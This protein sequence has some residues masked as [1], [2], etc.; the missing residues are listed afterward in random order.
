MSLEAIAPGD[1]D[2]VIGL[3][4]LIGTRLPIPPDAAIDRDD[5]VQECVLGALR[6]APRWRP[7][8]GTTFQAWVYRYADWAGRKLYERFEPRIRHRPKRDKG[9]RWFDDDPRRRRPIHFSAIE[10]PLEVLRALEVKRPLTVIEEA[11]L[12]A[13][14]SRL[15][16][17]D[18][19]IVALHLGAE[20]PL[21]RIAA[22]VGLS[23]GQ[24]RGRLRRALKALRLYAG[25]EVTP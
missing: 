9:K 10:D 13:A 3:A 18:R 23:V 24:A 8:G 2:G 20:V 15:E 12:R 22:G 4:R 1:L 16:A 21:Y 14:L 25:E 6:A 5:V 7:G 11:F 17:I 19:R